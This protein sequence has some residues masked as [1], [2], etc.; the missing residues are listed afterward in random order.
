MD[1]QKLAES[2]Y[3]YIPL[4]YLIP[5]KTTSDMYNWTARKIV[6]NAFIVFSKKIKPPVLHILLQGIEK[7]IQLLYSQRLKRNVS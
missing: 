3:K 5:N 6:K 1:L 7:I 4:C 2:G